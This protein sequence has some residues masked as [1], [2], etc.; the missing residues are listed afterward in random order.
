[1]PPAVPIFA[2]IAS[3]TSLGVTPSPNLPSTL[4]SIFFILVCT[5]H[6]VANTCST[7]LVPMP[8]ARQ[9]NAPWVAVC[10]SPHTTVIPGNTKPCSGPTTCTMPWRTSLM[11]NSVM[12]NL[13]QFSSS[14]ATCKRETSS[15]MPATPSLRS[16]ATVGTLWSGVA[17]FADKR[18]GSRLANDKPSNACGLVTSCNK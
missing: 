10:E 6:C 1:M 16:L 13:A 12:L 7:S 17:T 14:V 4:I 15:L 2:I 9:P 5:R 18:Q 8:W 3:T 11:V